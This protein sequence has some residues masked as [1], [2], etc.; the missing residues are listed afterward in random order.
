MKKA[1]QRLEDVQTP[2][3]KLTIYCFLIGVLV[4]CRK[5]SSIF[6]GGFGINWF[7][8]P[9]GVLLILLFIPVITWINW[10]GAYPPFIFN[11]F[12]VIET[13]FLLSVLSGIF[14]VRSIIKQ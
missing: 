12:Y 9:T 1:I 8:I 14:L 13:K 4:E 11:L 2:R 3:I 5:L 6:K 7:I 10:F